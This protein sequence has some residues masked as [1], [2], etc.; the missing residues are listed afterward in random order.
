MGLFQNIPDI[1]SFLSILTLSL[2]STRATQIKIL[3]NCTYT[4]WAA[5]N[6]G[7]GKQLKQG[8]TWTLNT[9][10]GSGRIWGRTKC[11][12]GLDGRGKCESGDCDGRLECPANG[13]APNTLAEYSI[14][15][16]NN[17]DVFYVSVVEGFNI[18]ME[19]SPASD[20]TAE[21]SKCAADVNGACP[22]EL[23]DP[24]G[25]NNPC[26]VFGNSQFCCTSGNICLPTSYSKFFKDLCPAAFTFPYDLGQRSTCP[27]GT[28]YKVVF[29]PSIK[30]GTIVD[31]N[32]TAQN[33]GCSP[34]LCCS[35][36]GYCGS[37]DEYCGEGCRSGPCKTT[38][39]T[40]TNNGGSLSDIVTPRFFTGILNKATG[41]CPG[42]SF[43]TRRG[44]LNAVNSYSQFG[45]GSVDESKREIA[46]FF[47]QISYETG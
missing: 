17:A 11:V 22:M 38:P 1:F 20:C 25:C 33:C 12:F 44:F 13:R 14:N 2:A 24:G 3:N 4:V 10:T 5:V 35:Q 9:T 40:P 7:G 18:P 41:D 46:A 16:T 45:N 43:Y 32:V 37:S 19:F 36:F 34:G 27:T 39:S 15:Q 31:K 29:C 42:K 30:T 21:E 8:E 28:H 26:T 23:R 47:A 6:P